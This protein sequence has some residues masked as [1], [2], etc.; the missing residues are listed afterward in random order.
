LKPGFKKGGKVPQHK[1]GVGKG[2][3]AGAKGSGK[4]F[5]KKAKGGGIGVKG[6][7]VPAA[8]PYPAPGQTRVAFGRRKAKGGAVAKKAE[9][10]A[11][12]LPADWS[13]M[14]D[15]Q[16]RDWAEEQTR[17]GKKAAAPAPKKEKPQTIDDVMK[18][19]NRA[20]GIASKAK[21]GWVSGEFFSKGVMKKVKTAPQD[22]AQRTAA[23]IV[24]SARTRAPLKN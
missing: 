4:V 24:K 3:D 7:A 16:K 10:G 19:S 18:E 14:T 11:I 23:D 17:P 5:M 8:A 15:A 1:G 13:K 12:A 2:P 20:M 21:G 9:G 22:K 6:A